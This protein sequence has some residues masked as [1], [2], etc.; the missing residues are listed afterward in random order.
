MNRPGGPR[1]PTVA[2]ATLGAQITPNGRPARNA[3]RRLRARDSSC[4]LVFSSSDPPEECLI[5]LALYGPS[6]ITTVSQP[7][8]C[9]SLSNQDRTLCHKWLRPAWPLSPGSNLETMQQ[10][11]GNDNQRTLVYVRFLNRRLRTSGYS[12]LCRTFRRPWTTHAGSASP[13]MPCPR[14]PCGSVCRHIASPG[15]SIRRRE[16]LCR[17][18]DW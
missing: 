4:G 13:A 5:A 18:T 7:A 16:H 8:A 12:G 3:I 1:Q 2:P 6:V 15:G 10:P 14:W 9:A 17:D 11:L